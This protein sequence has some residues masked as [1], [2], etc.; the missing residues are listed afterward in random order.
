[1]KMSD[2]SVFRGHLQSSSTLAASPGTHQRETLS[3][4]ASSVVS[5]CSWCN[6]GVQNTSRSSQGNLT[7]ILHLW[8]RLLRGPRRRRLKICKSKLGS[9]SGPWKWNHGNGDCSGQSV[10][11][12]PRLRAIF[13]RGLMQSV[14]LT[15]SSR[16]SVSVSCVSWYGALA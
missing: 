3:S 9:S 11:G 10:G 12:V 5:K 1:M 6:G 2:D 14:R 15:G 8:R 7:N 16:W 4:A 13:G